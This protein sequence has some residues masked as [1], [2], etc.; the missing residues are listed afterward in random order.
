MILIP[1]NKTYGTEELNKYLAQHITALSPTTATHEIIA[2]FNKHYYAVGDRVMY[3]KED[4]TII[5]ISI[6]GLYVGAKYQAASTLLD[7]WGNYRTPAETDSIGTSHSETKA[8]ETPE[9]IDALLDAMNFG[10]GGA[11]GDEERKREASHAVTL[12]LHESQE[13][14]TLTTA[15]DLNNLALGYAITVHKA[16]GSE[17]RKVFLLLHESHASMLQRELLYTAVTRARESLY[18]ICPPDAFVKGILRQKIKGNTL[19]EKLE[20]FKGKQERNEMQ[21]PLALSTK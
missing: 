19:A 15:S 21:Q 4:A 17:A 20:F 11:G 2:G 10:D 8:A 6:N 12:L 14:V 1:F 13:E 7:R 5:A 18:V 3:E 16:Q 9:D